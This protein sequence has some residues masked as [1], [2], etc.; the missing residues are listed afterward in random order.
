[1]KL[2]NASIKRVLETFEDVELGDPRRHRR[3]QKM[4]QQACEA[5]RRQFS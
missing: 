1:M 4:L 2:P 3:L 5:A